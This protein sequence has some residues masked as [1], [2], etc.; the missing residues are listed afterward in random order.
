MTRFSRRSMLRWG[1]A[2]AAAS[3]LPTAFSLGRRRALAQ[4]RADQRFLFVVTASGGGSI[5]DSF[6][7]VAESE[8]PDREAAQR[9]VQRVR[10]V[11]RKRHAG[12]GCT[13]V[14]GC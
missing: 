12:R 9:S 5:I 10:I 14:A 2:A 13:R 1:A 3:A 4:P 7:P 11:V 6:L 8:A